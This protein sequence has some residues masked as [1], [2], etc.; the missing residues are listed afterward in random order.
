MAFQKDV[1]VS[2]VMYEIFCPH[3]F[4]KYQLTGFSNYLGNF[5]S[6]K[7]PYFNFTCIL[8]FCFLVLLIVVF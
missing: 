6:K 7:L 5:I 3:E 8:H 1:L 2:S 4:A